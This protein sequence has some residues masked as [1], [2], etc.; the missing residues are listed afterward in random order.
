MVHYVQQLIASAR[1]LFAR[2]KELNS[3]QTVTDTERAALEAELATITQEE[4][5]ERLAESDKSIQHLDTANDHETEG[6][7]LDTITALRN[8]GWPPTP[9]IDTLPIKPVETAS[10]SGSV[11]DRPTVGGS[12]SI[13][14]RATI[15]TSPRSKRLSPD[16]NRKHME[17]HSQQDVSGKKVK[18]VLAHSI[19]ETHSG[20]RLPGWQH[21]K[22]VATG[23]QRGGVSGG[24]RPTTL[25]RSKSAKKTSMVLLACIRGVSL[26]GTKK[27]HD[28]IIPQMSLTGRISANGVWPTPCSVWSKDFGPMRQ[29]KDNRRGTT[30]MS[31]IRTTGLQRLDEETRHSSLVKL[32]FRCVPIMVK[33]VEKLH[34]LNKRANA[35]KNDERR[36]DAPRRKNAP[37]YERLSM[38]R[39][40]CVRRSS[41]S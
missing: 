28:R 30:T 35:V 1:A 12:A 26:G 34:R 2:L 41:S 38:A 5:R 19:K 7:F 39:T 37:N 29:T 13:Q 16:P 33:L 21:K 3:K 22:Q 25:A 23:P 32:V 14:E 8:S 9:A 24:A 31:A 6:F 17:E 36:S 27:A 4:E 10:P 20:R 40:A 18:T 15:M 11:I